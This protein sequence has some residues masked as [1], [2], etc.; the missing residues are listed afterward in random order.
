[1]RENGCSYVRLGKVWHRKQAYAVGGLF[2]NI[3]V[4]AYLPSV[5]RLVQPPDTLVA[6]Y[7]RSVPHIA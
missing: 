4:R 1:M 7:A 2:R 6:P 3:T 5:G